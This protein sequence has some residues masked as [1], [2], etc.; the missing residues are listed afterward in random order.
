MT[1][2]QR[3]VDGH[4]PSALASANDDLRSKNRAALAA[5]RKLRATNRSTVEEFIAGLRRH[6]DLWLAV[7]QLGIV[8]FAHT[9]LGKHRRTSSAK[10]A[11]APRRTRINDEQ[12]SVLKTAVVRALSSQPDGLSRVELAA[13]VADSG[14]VPVGSTGEEFGKFIRE[15]YARWLPAVRASGATLD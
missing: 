13:V 7:S 6:P 14:S 9:L 2:A 8:D 10:G 4:Y 5:F 12:K 1:S 15:E 3:A 11:T